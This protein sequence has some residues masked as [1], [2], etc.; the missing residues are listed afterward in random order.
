MDALERNSRRTGGFKR[1]TSGARALTKAAGGLW[2]EYSF[3]W[4]PFLNDI[5]EGLKAY[6]RIWA[7]IP[8]QK[9]ISAG[10]R[11]SY[12]RSRELSSYDTPG[13]LQNHCGVVNY[14]WRVLSSSWIETHD[15]RYRGAIRRSVTRPRWENAVELLGFKPLEFIP[16]AWEL[17]PWSFLIDYA[18]NIGDILQAVATD[19]SSVVYTSRSSRLFSQYQGIMEGDKAGS[20]ATLGASWQTDSFVK[21]RA[22]WIMNRKLLTRSKVGAV[23]LPTLSLSWDFTDGQRLNVA[24]LLTNAIGLHPQRKR[25]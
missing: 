16:T 22:E 1:G 9:K 14:R 4:V 11:V 19:T 10:Y 2:L 13:S 6:E 8:E 21:S 7:E 23:P 17:M 20:V 15:I 25:F 5:Q 24:A 3:G 18:T 12:D